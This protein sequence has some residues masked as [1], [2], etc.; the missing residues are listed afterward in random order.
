MGQF[1]SAEVEKEAVR[2]AAAMMAA[3][4]RTAPK[5]KGL[6]AVKT[7]LV[8]GD[9]IELIAGAMEAKGKEKPESL[10]AIFPRDAANVRKSACILLVGVTA[11]P[12]AMRPVSSL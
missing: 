8:D 3:S 5:A 11:E 4:A 2:M 7:L 9:D 1:N 6:D 12:V 10:S